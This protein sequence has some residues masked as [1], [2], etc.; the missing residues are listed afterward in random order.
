MSFP[1]HR[2]IFPSD[3]G[4]GFATGTPAHRLDEFPAGYSLAGWSPPAPASAS[5]AG[6]EYAVHPPCW[7]TT[8]QRTARCVLTICLTRGGKR[9]FMLNVENF[10]V[11]KYRCGKCSRVGPTLLDPL[12]FV[13]LITLGAAAAEFVAPAGYGIQF[14]TTRMP[15]P[16]GRSCSDPTC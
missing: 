8:F 10:N 15:R 6:S 1:R 11:K 2:E 14:E 5:P 4:A 16:D 12:G 3:G 13:L 9:T 7:S